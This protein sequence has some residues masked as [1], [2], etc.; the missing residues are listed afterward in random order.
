MKLTLALALILAV[1]INVSQQQGNDGSTTIDD[2]LERI[3]RAADE[4]YGTSS[5]GE[6]LTNSCISEQ[7]TFYYDSHS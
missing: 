5:T 3:M 2:R 7:R 6:Y 1:F 4:H